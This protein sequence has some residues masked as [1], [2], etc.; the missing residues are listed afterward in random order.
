MK[1]LPIRLFLL[2][3]FLYLKTGD[4]YLLVNSRSLQIKNLLNELSAKKMYDVIVVRLWCK[5][6]FCRINPDYAAFPVI[7]TLN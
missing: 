4:E 5:T 3:A 6:L 2:F 7:C 1:R